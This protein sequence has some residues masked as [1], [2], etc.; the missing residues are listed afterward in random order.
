MSIPDLT[1]PSNF[2]LTVVLLYI[3]ITGRYFLVSGFFYLFF[4]KWFK[5]HWHG[6][7]LGN[8]QYTPEQLRR[9]IKWSVITS[10][11]FAF[12][13][14][15]LLLLY[16]LGYTRI[17]TNVFDYPVWWMPVSLFLS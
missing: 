10:T 11:C 14:T 3:I 7:K 16:Q 2:I 9:E 4:Y 6:R 15:V 17:Y 8:K 13:G 1:Q 5:M 12:T